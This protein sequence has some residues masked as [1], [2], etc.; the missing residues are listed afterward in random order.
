MVYAPGRDSVPGP[1]ETVEY[2]PARGAGGVFA[3]FMQG[4]TAKYSQNTD[5]YRSD[6]YRNTLARLFI[7]VDATEMNLFA[8]SVSD[9]HT[10]SQLVPRIAGTVARRQPNRTTGGAG[11]ND[12]NARADQTASTNGYLDFCIQ[13]ASMPLQE[14]LDLKETLADNY[15]AYFFGQAPPMWTFSG[16]LFNSVQDDQ[17]TNFLRLYLEILRGTQLARRQKVVSLK[18]DSYII[19]GAI[20]ATNFSLQS[21]M[22]VVVP[23]Q[24]QMLVKHVAVVN[25]TVGWT[26]TWA[27]TPFAADPNAIPYDGRRIGTGS[28]TAAAARLPAN[29]PEQGPVP[30]NTADAR[31]TQPAAPTDPLTEQS[32]SATRTPARNG[33][34]TNTTP[35]GARYVESTA[36]TTGA[37][38]GT[39]PTG[40]VATP[41]TRPGVSSP[42]GRPSS[43]PQRAAQ[44][45]VA[46]ASVHSPTPEAVTLS[47][48]R[49]YSISGPTSNFFEILP[50]TP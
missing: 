16:W 2:N 6:F 25:Y 23:F 34:A 4:M 26:P 33:Q 36:N 47:A 22:E 29:I 40:P 7:R 31:T 10:E 24:F 13:Q 17:A 48:A 8:S 19:T 42:P 30:E 41:A 50:R 37:V 21:N 43:A 35:R 44:A 15:V 39:R 3:N 20:V 14:K 28:R 11:V 32:N 5:G 18:I 38:A 45:Q 12:A 46:E 1:N 49:G 27:S 9:Q